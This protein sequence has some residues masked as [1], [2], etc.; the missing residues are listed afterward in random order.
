MAFFR[1]H[2]FGLCLVFCLGFVF[3]FS[4]IAEGQAV[5]KANKKVSEV[6]AQD[7]FDQLRKTGFDLI[8]AGKW[9]E[10]HLIFEQILLSLPKDATSLYG[11]AL[12]L[13]NLQRLPEAESAVGSA[14]EI[15]SQEKTNS[16]LLADVL[17]LSAVISATQKDNR[18]AIDKLLKA[19]K[20]SD[21]HFDASLTL[22]R[23]YYGQGNTEKAVEYFKRAVKI[24]PANIQAK[25]FLAT[26]LERIGNDRE[27]LQEYRAILK[28]APENANGNLGLGVLLIKL[29]GNASAEGLK[30]LQKAVAINENL[31]EAQITLGKALLRSNLLEQA[32][33]HL[34]K[35]TEIN[36]LIP[37][38]HYQLALAY[39][40][41]GKKKEAENQMQIVK[42]IHETRRNVADN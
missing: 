6:I 30:A 34:K 31:Y 8:R 39:R 23:T 7:D 1:Q 17:V 4:G 24:Q 37:E 22:A 21:N 40:K 18:T 19:V 32:I 28:I 27:A 26:A 33:V 38:P 13:F 10:A 20:L 16:N 2:I 3:T 12:A 14:V 41:L 15:L 11:D 5:D 35:A 36:P 9:L 42:R 25:F 29:E